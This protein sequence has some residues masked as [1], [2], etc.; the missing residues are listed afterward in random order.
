M[1]TV[2]TCLSVRPWPIRLHWKFCEKVVLKPINSLAEL[3]HL[4]RHRRYLKTK[5][6]VSGVSPN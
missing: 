2:L 4:L 6:S 5:I 3:Y 1:Q